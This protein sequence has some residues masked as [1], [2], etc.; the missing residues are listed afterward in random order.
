MVLKANHEMASQ[1]LR[2][3]GYAW[4]D[5]N[6]SSEK[7]D[8]LSIEK[9]EKKLI[10][11]GLTGMIDPPREEVKPSINLC[12]QAGI[13]PVMITGDH[14]LTACAIAKELGILQEQDRA[15]SG[16]ELDMISEDDFKK[17]APRIS[18]YARV[19]PAH[20][21]R[22]VHTLQDLG[23]VVA[24]T[25]D[26]VNDVPALK[27]ADIGIAMGITG[28]DVTKQAA[29]MVL[30]DDNFNTIVCAVEEGRIIYDNIIKFIRFLLSSNFGEVVAMLAAIITGII[31]PG[32]PMPFALVQILWVNLLTD[33]FPAIALGIDPGD[34]DIMLRRPNKPDKSVFADG[35]M[36]EIFL[37]G[38]QIGLLTLAVFS[39]VLYIEGFWVA[40]IEESSDILLKA[41]SAAFTA[42][43]FFQL[44]YVFRCPDRSG[45]FFRPGMF[46]NIW[47]VGAFILSALLQLIVLYTPFLQNIFYTTNLGSEKIFSYWFIIIPAGFLMLIPFPFFEKKQVT[48]QET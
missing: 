13:R 37:R 34:P 10:F 3:L 38:L 19:S 29:D 43:V 14:K 26:G 25:G 5:Y 24:M 9:A 18:V 46:K 40:G 32:F 23:H 15:V 42:L 27:E 20:K 17:E 8:T 41:R 33:S 11:I 30:A 4:R 48:N 1:A 47:L 21:L 22:I 31:Y 35:L 45:R 39:C 16:S 2:V 6:E 36:A 7:A 28:T 44:F 12:R